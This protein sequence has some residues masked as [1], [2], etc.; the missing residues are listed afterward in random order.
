VTDI[1]KEEVELMDKARG[2]EITNVANLVREHKDDTKDDF[3]S[4]WKAID[5]MLVKVGI[6][7]SIITAAINFGFKVANQ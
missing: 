3:K 4:V 6:V 1:T 7:V 2:K 5:M